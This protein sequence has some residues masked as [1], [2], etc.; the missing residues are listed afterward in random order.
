VWDVAL[1]YAGEFSGVKLA[2][3]I[4]YTAWSDD[5]NGLAV[6]PRNC[7]RIAGKT[8]ANCDELGLSASIMHVPTGLYVSGS[9]GTRTEDNR[10]ALVAAAVAGATTRKNDDWYYVQA[11]IEQAFFPLGK[12]TFFGEY[13]DGRFGAA[14][15]TNSSA[16][17]KDVNL[18]GAT[19]VAITG[20]DATYW[21]VGFNQNV[22]AAAM[23]IY[24]SYRNYSFDVKGV[25]AANVGQ[26][27]T[28]NDMQTVVMGAKIQF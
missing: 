6:N 26:V 11:G 27:S 8:T 16:V 2:A 7:A 10:Q 1:R 3:G 22:A 21:G 19:N 14:V 28:A 17:V 24:V 15:G 23:D 25:T 20:T 12:S 18:L 13:F 9:Y 5:Q 4:G